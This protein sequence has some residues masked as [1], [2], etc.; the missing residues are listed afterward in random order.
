MEAA[1]FLYPD[2]LL[3]RVAHWSPPVSPFEPR[4]KRLNS[5]LRFAAIVGERLFH[6]LRYEG[7][8]FLLTPDTWRYILKYEQLDFIIIESCWQSVTGHWYL[9]QT[10]H[11]ESQQQLFDILA[12][13]KKG[14]IPTIYWITQDHSYHRHYCDFARNADF[15]FCADAHEIE[16]LKKEGIAAELLLPAV[17]PAVHNP[18]KDFVPGQPFEIPILFDGFADIYKYTDELAVLKEIC[19]DGLSI[20]D[21]QSQILKVKIKD[22][23]GYASNILGSVTFDGRLT[24]LKH[25]RVALTF[26]TTLQP[27]TSQQWMAIEAAACHVPVIYRGGLGPTDIRNTIVIERESDNDLLVELTSFKE[28]DLYRE[29]VAHLGW[30]QVYQNHTFSH[31]MRVIAQTIGCEHS[32]QEYP[33]VSVITPTFREHLIPDCM[34]RFAEQNYPRKELVLIFNGQNI[35]S[36][37]VE[38]LLLDVDQVRMFSVPSDRFA[39]T[40][41]NV[42][43]EVA[44]GEY[45]FRMDDDDIYGENYIVDM[46]L[47]LRA[48]DA[49]VFGKPPIYCKFENDDNLYSRAPSVRSHCAV[50]ANLFTDG[51]IWLAGNTISGKR[52]ILVNVKYPEDIFGAADA[53]FTA[54]ACRDGVEEI[55]CFDKFNMVASRRSDILSHT[56]RDSPE[57]IKSGSMVMRGASVGDVTL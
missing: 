45:C 30:R 10:V 20:I 47:Y 33:L 22:I 49:E 42:G 50:P 27:V 56:W 12:E 48:V 26:D 6:G 52:E 51:K 37:A 44:R 38:K 54:I 7:E 16:L 25:S 8:L 5:S 41:L 32:W 31:R 57:S 21:S 34:Q 35:D 4:K 28:D 18:I 19:D 39:G 55:Y 29:R 15:V 13:A 24:A 3:E 2:E 23:P 1:N 36:R 17:Q 43:N 9:G 53:A 14:S 11:G 46:M 40:C